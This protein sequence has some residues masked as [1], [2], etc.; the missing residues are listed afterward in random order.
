MVNFVSIEL[1]KMELFVTIGQEKPEIDRLIDFGGW[2]M[3]QK[4][5]H[6]SLGWAY[7]AYPFGGNVRMHVD[8]GI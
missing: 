2:S 7:C 1:S 3:E 6:A 5:L 4:L 8:K